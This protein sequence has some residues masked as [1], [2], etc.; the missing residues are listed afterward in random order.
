MTKSQ[1]ML[2]KLT[3]NPY[4]KMINLGHSIS[5][6]LIEVSKWEK[7]EKQNYG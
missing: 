2:K 1:R 5:L 3:V 6:K 4:G 7:K